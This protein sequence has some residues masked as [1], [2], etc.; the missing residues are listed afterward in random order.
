MQG[1][2]AKY[3]YGGCECDAQLPVTRNQLLEELA[4]SSDGS[5]PA[6][7]IVEIADRCA[8]QAFLSGRAVGHND[9]F[10]TALEGQQ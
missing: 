10:A 4:K 9:G 1:N 5:L 8:S 2:L 6:D 7:R 3:E